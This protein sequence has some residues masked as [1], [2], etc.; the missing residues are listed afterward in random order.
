MVPVPS[1]RKKIRDAALGA[2]VGRYVDEIERALD[3]HVDQGRAPK[4]EAEAVL[5]EVLEV[6]AREK[7]GDKVVFMETGTFETGKLDEDDEDDASEWPDQLP[8][9]ARESD[10]LEAGGE[11]GT[12]DPEYSGPIKLPER[13]H[14]PDELLPD[15]KVRDPGD[16]RD[17]DAPSDPTG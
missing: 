15:D 1:R 7:L 3:T 8:R 16:P 2:T 9:A 5:R 10:R 14:E 13:I 12:E 4:E 6:L 17:P 11:A